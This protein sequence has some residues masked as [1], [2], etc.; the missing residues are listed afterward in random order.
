M[1]HSA[2]VYAQI[3][4]HQSGCTRYLLLDEPTTFLDIR[5]QHLFLRLAQQIAASGAVV[6]AVL[7][8]IHL[9]ARYANRI[10]PLQGGRL[11]AGGETSGV[12]TPA[13]F[14]ELYGIDAIAHRSSDNGF[15]LV[16]F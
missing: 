3:I 5:H 1:V 16:I 11:P 7:H 4:G 6:V 13:F 10:V 14:G 2:R 15:P 12:F 8:D 9:T